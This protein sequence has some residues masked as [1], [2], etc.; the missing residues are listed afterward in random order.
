MSTAQ[1]E[2]IHDRYRKGFVGRSR[3]TRDLAQLDSIIADTES[4]LGG[5]LESS[6]RNK[7]QERLDLYRGERTEIAAIQAGG[8]AALVGWRAAEWSELLYGQYRRHFAGQNRTT[9][10]LGLLGELVSDERGNLAAIPESADGRL[11]QRRATIKANLGMYE[12]ELVEIPKARNLMAPT[13]QARLLATLANEQFELWR[14][15][16]QGRMRMTRRP[17]LLKRMV[18]TLDAI[19]GRMEAL[20][21]MGVRNDAHLSNIGKVAERASHFRSELAQIEAA[22]AQAPGLDLSRRLG[23]DANAIFKAYRE[24]FSG[25]SRAAADLSRLST[26]C[27]DLHE[28]ART[29][30]L[31]DDERPIDQNAQNLTIVLDHLKMMEREFVSISDAKKAKR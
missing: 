13:D 30:R 20:R 10:D 17:A 4:L 18:D 9:R 22:R 28:V 29:M 21:D 5:S 11:A 7:V 14:R 6:L 31:L 1:A 15:Y 27:D 2:A 23:D 19:R 12:A 16:F 26:L 25:K 8:P 3:A 24:E